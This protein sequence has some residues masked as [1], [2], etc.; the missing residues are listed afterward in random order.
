MAASAGRGNQGKTRTQRGGIRLR[1]GRTNEASFHELHARIEAK[2]TA[3]FLP[4]Q[5]YKAGADST[6]RK[7][8]GPWAYGQADGAAKADLRRASKSS[9]TDDSRSE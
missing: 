9:G 3:E 7:R 8:R 5:N 4:Q 1:R 2:S 6:Q